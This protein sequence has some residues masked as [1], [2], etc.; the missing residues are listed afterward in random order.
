MP[1]REIL[2]LQQFVRTGDS[3]AF[4]QIV[5]RHA[6][7]VYGAS[8][9][10]LE[11]TAQAADVAQETFLQLLRDAG[12]I[13]GSVSSWL[14]RV[15]TRRAIDTLRS[16]SRRKLRE[17]KYAAEKPLETTRWE[18]MSI[19]VDE[20]LE[21]LDDQTREILIQHF[22]QGQTAT[23]IAEQMEIS[24]PTASRRIESG[25][26]QLRHGLKNRGILV[27]AGALGS[28]LAGNA[29]Q[30]APAAVLK[31]LGKIALVGSAATT[32]TAGTSAITSGASKVGASVAIGVKAKVITATVI[33]AVGIG[34]IATYKH[35]S[36]PDPE[37]KPQTRP[38]ASAP[39][40]KS[41]QRTT[42]F[43]AVRQVTSQ[44]YTPATVTETES[45]RVASTEPIENT[46]K[47]EETAR[48]V[49]ESTSEP[50]EQPTGYGFIGGR[51]FGGYGSRMADSHDT[52]NEEQPEE[53]NG[54]QNRETRIGR[55]RGRRRR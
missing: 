39:I 24:Q 37:P 9:R 8:L 55:S 46:D 27:A 31:E 26:A 21:E 28:L 5:H 17:A 43:P 36:A 11:D 35:V 54:P 45:P 33:A 42:T 4:S 51:M 41:V 38:K 1:D 13:R 44:T 18:D 48:P 32:S 16:E 50:E 34:G 52:E 25:V 20:G 53:P 7:L 10:I 15:A 40:E 30:A 14:H 12:K 22:F 29:A 19:Y 23:D 49:V 3:E 6:G 2:L 47:P